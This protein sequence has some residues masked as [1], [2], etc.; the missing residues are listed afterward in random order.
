MKH[1]PMV[2]INSAEMKAS[3]LRMPK[4]LHGQQQEHVA[5]R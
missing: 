5:R 1:K 2:E 3:I 4:S